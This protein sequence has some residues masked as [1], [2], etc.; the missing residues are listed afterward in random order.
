MGTTPQR[1]M[2][3]RGKEWLKVLDVN[4]RDRLKASSEPVVEDIRREIKRPGRGKLRRSTK[5]GLYKASRSGEALKSPSR[6]LLNS[7]EYEIGR[8]PKGLGSR[9]GIGPAFSRFAT[10]ARK[11]F[12]GKQRGIHGQRPTLRPA[13]KKN[14]PKIRKIWGL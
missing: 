5:A 12:L 4:F 9:I 2:V 11:M 1:Q 3:W 6:D 10:T 13:L 8:S 14:W 7:I